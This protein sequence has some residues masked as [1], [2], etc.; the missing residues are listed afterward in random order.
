[1]L[2]AQSRRAAAELGARWAPEVVARAGNL[3]RRRRR[4][5]LQLE[6]Q[7]AALRYR[8]EILARRKR[9]KNMSTASKRGRPGVLL[10]KDVRCLWPAAGAE[11][12]CS[13]GSNRPSSALE[14]KISTPP[15]QV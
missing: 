3:A 12:N 2:L 10:F 9:Q 1:M 14:P 15:K 5:K 7:L 4:K 11:K 8:L 13:Q 6:R